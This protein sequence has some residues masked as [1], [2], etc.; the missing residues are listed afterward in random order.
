MKKLFLLSFLG[1]ASSF[2]QIKSDKK[3]L[4]SLKKLLLFTFLTFSFS[5]FSQT[6][7]G[8]KIGFASTGVTTDY[9]PILNYKNGFGFHAGFF[10]DIMAG[11]DFFLQPTVQF[12]THTATAETK[13]SSIKA[14]ETH[15]QTP[16]NMV[17]KFDGFQLGGG[18]QWSFPLSSGETRFGLNALVGYEISEKASLQLSYNFDLKK[19]Y[20]TNKNAIGISLLST[21]GK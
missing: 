19:S 5:S 12:V 9:A 3:M 18:P 4:L 14:T 6:K 16:I 13:L 8:F 15:I 10:L 11:D 17:F 1:S 21:F 7:A 2:S 20:S